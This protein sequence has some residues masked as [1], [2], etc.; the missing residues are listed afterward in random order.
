MND[1]DTSATEMMRDFTLTN[2]DI[3]RLMK[4][5]DKDVIPGTESF[6]SRLVGSISN[7]FQRFSNAL[8]EQFYS[9]EAVLTQNWK[10][11]AE[12]WIE[13]LN[14]NLPDTEQFTGTISLRGTK[15]MAEKNKAAMMA[16]VNLTS[17]LDRVILS[18]EKDVLPRELRQVISYLEMSNCKVDP[19]RPSQSS[20]ATRFTYGELGRLG[21][22]GYGSEP[23][24]YVSAMKHGIDD[25]YRIYSTMTNSQFT[26]IAIKK[27]EAEV[28]RLAAAMEK[29][30][31]SKK[32][33]MAQQINNIRARMVAYRSILRATIDLWNTTLITH[34][35]I[36]L[37]NLGRK[38]GLKDDF[39]SWIL[40]TKED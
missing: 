16:V 12:R 1:I 3:V 36:P 20:A 4:Y 25:W 13:R 5:S 30:P 11:Y 27:M 2:N 24:I 38:A 33:D 26:D 18:P 19:A 9:W 37:Q 6:L 40:A 29:A 21:T 10:Q 35:V 22:S 31:D 28:N 34:Y 32:L 17:H 39:L 23:S 8:H 7:I 15:Q 14:N